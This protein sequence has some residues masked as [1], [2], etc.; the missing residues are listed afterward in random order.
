MKKC[1]AAALGL[2]ALAAPSPGF[3][4][5]SAGSPMSLY[6]TDMSGRD[7]Q[8]LAAAGEEGLMQERLGDLASKRAWTGPVKTFGEALLSDRAAENDEL[9]RL[10][11]AKRVTLPTALTAQQKQVDR[12]L[13][14]LSGEKFN[15]ACVDQIIEVQQQ[16]IADYESVTQSKD[17]QIRGFAEKTLPP[18]KEHLLLAK[19]IAG[20]NSAGTLFKARMP[21]FGVAPNA[22][23][24]IAEGQ[25][26]AS[27]PAAPGAPA[28]AEG[29]LELA[30]AK[31][32]AGWAYDPGNPN[33]P[34]ALEIYDGTTMLSTVVAKEFRGDLK[35]NGKGDGKHFFMVSTPPNIKDGKAHWI[36][37]TVATTHFELP[38]SP[39][40]VLY[41]VK[42]P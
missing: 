34:V 42:A 20:I 2:A 32:I 8:F 11:A 31:L 38:G 12:R 15:K 7:L 14:K 27:T 39:K 19:K 29:S 35:A 23:K 37:V 24:P 22:P 33:A 5:P 10:A 41:P 4:K 13:S 25:G 36:R 1:L 18:L 26:A 9:K 40:S 21:V 30:D 3:G 28:G 16:Q 17:R 6:N